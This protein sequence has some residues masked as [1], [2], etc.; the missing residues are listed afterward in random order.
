MLIIHTSHSAISC[1]WAI[2]GVN[3]GIV[4]MCRYMMI[5]IYM[6]VYACSEDAGT[7][8]FKRVLRLPCCVFLDFLA[9]LYLLV[10]C[11][12]YYWCSTV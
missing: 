10:L 4:N 12:L 9:F 7:G 3:V 11:F 1:I 8:D 2:S 6:I 5:Y